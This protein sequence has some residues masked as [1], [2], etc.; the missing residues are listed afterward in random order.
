MIKCGLHRRP[1]RSSTSSRPTPSVRTDPARRPHILPSSS[2]APIAVKAEVVAEDLKEAGL[3]EILNYGHT[4]AHAIEHV[5]RLPV[6]A[7]RRGL[8]RHGLRRRAGR[9]A[10]RL[11]RRRSSTGT[12]RSSTSLGLPVTYRGDR[13]AGS[14]ATHER[15][16]R[17][18]AATCCASSSSTDSAS[19]S[20]LEGPDPALL[21]PTPRS[22]GAPAPSRRLLDGGAPRL[23]HDARAGA[24]RPEPR[25]ARLRE[26]EVY[27]SRPYADLVDGCTRLGR[28]ARPRR[29][30]PADRRRGAS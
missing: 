2:S 27:G 5:E 20:A 15:S 7:R 6:A 28:R 17:R 30:G 23:R 14:C 9:L 24:Q 29:R 26:P 16:T 8:G 4:L 1:A 3:R 21:P 18:P 25:P 19:P 13:W 12:A 10:G 11:T 22:A